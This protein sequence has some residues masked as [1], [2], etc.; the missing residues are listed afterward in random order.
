LSDFL[1]LQERLATNKPAS[2]S[3]ERSIE[4]RILQ[5][6]HFDRLVARNMPERLRCIRRELWITHSVTP[7]MLLIH[8]RLV[9]HPF[10]Y[11][12]LREELS[13]YGTAVKHRQNV[14]SSQVEGFTAQEALQHNRDAVLVV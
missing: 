7:S 13:R 9:R 3:Q 12:R 8:S 14:I 6:I 4:R 1:A 11:A 10:D 5:E 2:C